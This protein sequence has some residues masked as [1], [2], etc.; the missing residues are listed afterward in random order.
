MLFTN[1]MCLI[2]MY[3]YCLLTKAHECVLMKNEQTYPKM[4]I[5]MIFLIK[6]LNFH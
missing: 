2:F 6:P 5:K 3:E 1:L 4:N